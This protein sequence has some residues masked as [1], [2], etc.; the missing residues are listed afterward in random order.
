VQNDELLGSWLF[1]FSCVPAI[2]YSLVYL[3]EGSYRSLIYLG[4]LGLAIV[5]CIA[6]FM[7]V[8]ACYPSDATVSNALYAGGEQMIALCLHSRLRWATI[9]FLH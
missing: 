4:M 1:F 5:V 7:F 9:L 3:S 8:L 6:C 2:P